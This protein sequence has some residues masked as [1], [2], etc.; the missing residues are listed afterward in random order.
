MGRS[1][2]TLGNTCEEQEPKEI[3]ETEF[4]RKHES[5]HTQ[6]IELSRLMILHLKF[7]Y[8]GSSVSQ[9]LSSLKKIELELLGNSE[10]GLK[11]GQTVIPKLSPKK[12]H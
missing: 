11:K 1:Q 6:K 4:E 12:R 5:A 7:T 3:R 8:L 2:E 9:I 10:E